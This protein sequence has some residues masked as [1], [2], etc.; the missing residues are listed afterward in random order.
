[1]EWKGKKNGIKTNLEN[2]VEIFFDQWDEKQW[3]KGNDIS[4][5]REGAL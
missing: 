2:S 5:T 1:M 3:Q 4:S